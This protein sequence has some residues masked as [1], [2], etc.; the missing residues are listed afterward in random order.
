MISTHSDFPARAHVRVNETKIVTMLMNEGWGW[1]SGSGSVP[2]PVPHDCYTVV[3]LMENTT[4][5]LRAMHPC[6]VANCACDGVYFR[7]LS[8]QQRLVIHVTFYSAVTPKV[9]PQVSPLSHA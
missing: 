3:Q 4:L 5:K 7:N 8:C 1:G 9:P 6:I 2:V